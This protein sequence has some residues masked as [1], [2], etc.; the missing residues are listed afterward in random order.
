MTGR[1]LHN[2]EILDKVGEG[3][4]GVV[5]KARD[6]RLNRLVAP[7]LLRHDQSLSREQRF[8]L[9]R[10]A[11]TASSLNHPNIVT[12]YDVQCESDEDYIALEYVEGQTL[13]RLIGRDGLPVQVA[14]RY[15]LEIPDALEAAHRAGVVHRDLKPT[16]VIVNSDDRVKVVDFGLAKK[17]PE[18]KPVSPV[19]ETRSMAMHNR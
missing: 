15:A 5:Y 4:M 18:L 13:D 2:Y 12:V 1:I 6:V 14:I 10:E 19:A 9:L 11:Q 16:N 7:K 8:R 3:G 17:R